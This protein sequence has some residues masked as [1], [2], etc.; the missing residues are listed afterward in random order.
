MVRP[1]RLPD[2]A[3]LFECPLTTGH[4]EP[5]PL[6]WLKDAPPPPAPS[7]AKG[8]AG[9]GNGRGSGGSS[10]LAKEL[11]L[12]VELP[13]ALAE[14][15]GRWVEY[16]VLEHTYARRRPDDFA[17]LV[18]IYGH[19]T[20]AAKTYT[21]SSYLAGR[22][23]DLARHGKVVLRFGPATGRWDYNPEIS[24]WT[25]SPTPDWADCTSWKD[26]GE[27]MDYVPGSTE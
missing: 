22:L 26:L 6:R 19:T 27:P 11:D 2:G 25:L 16:G 8:A 21:S 18:E 9:S 17:R 4:I 1:R 15:R 5:G 24:W 10:G 12:G 7:P 13:A 14:Y 23:G 20:I 3:L